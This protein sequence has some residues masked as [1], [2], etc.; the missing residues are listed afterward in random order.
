[1]SRVWITRSEP[2]A[3]RTARSLGEARYIPLLAPVLAA[4]YA[5]TVE[6]DP[7]IYQAVLF[8]SVHGVHGLRRVM[9]RR[10]KA[11]CVGDATTDEAQFAGFDAESA[12]G[13]GQALAALVRE[14]LDPADGPLLHACGAHIAYDLGEALAADGFQ[15]DPARVYEA[16]A[17]EALPPKAA[18]ALNKGRLDAALFHSARAAEIFMT[19]TQPDQRAGLTCVAI[20]KRAA[21]PLDGQATIA[22]TPDEAALIAALKRVCPPTG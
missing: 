7:D 3:H 20:S 8:T 10:P 19:L 4:Y 12:A 9:T 14:R 18:K 6:I 17:V 22:D 16:R 11:F 2:G 13:D 1:M 21:A 15:V 5:E